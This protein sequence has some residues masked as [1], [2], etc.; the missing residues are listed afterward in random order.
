MDLISEGSE[1]SACGLALQLKSSCVNLLN[2]AAT[3]QLRADKELLALSSEVAGL[4]DVLT[5]L[6]LT[7]PE[8]RARAHCTVIGKLVQQIEERDNGSHD[9]TT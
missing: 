8:E 1:V 7:N 3:G 2:A 9:P 6:H 4:F 5:G